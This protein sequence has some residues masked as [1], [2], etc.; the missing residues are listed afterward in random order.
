MIH[1]GIVAPLMTSPSRLT[2]FVS[3]TVRDFGPVR[4]DLKAWLEARAIYAR[5]SEHN[6]FPVA[7]GVHSHD[8]CLAAIAGCNLYVL[9]VGERYGGRYKGTPKSITWRE[10]DE[11][12]EHQI[13][14]VALVLKSA[15]DLTMELSKAR[16]SGNEARLTKLR[17]ELPRDFE[18][19]AKFID[20]L[21]KGHRDN[22]MYMDW[23]GSASG[24]TEVIQY[25]LNNL[26]CDYQGPYQELV[27]G[28]ELAAARAAALRD[29]QAA[30]FELSH[31]DARG[32]PSVGEALGRLLA[33]AASARRELF[34]FEPGEVWNLQLY[35]KEG[36][37]LIPWVRQCDKRIERQERRW[38]LDEGHVGL[39]VTAR[40][41]LVA[42][43]LPVA[44]GFVA[45][46]PADAHNYRSAVSVP[47]LGPP[48]GAAYVTR[49]KV[50]GVAHLSAT[51]DTIGA[52]VITSSRLDHFLE[53]N[54]PEVLTAEQL[55]LMLRMVATAA[56]SAAF[57]L[58]DRTAPKDVGA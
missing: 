47:L 8:S 30:T 42:G 49:K 58:D 5:L 35:R 18:N 38:K 56:P 39:A 34:K 57:A 52:F 12:Y 21:R 29:L 31:A 37:L 3:S 54:Q 50:A 43:D 55:C 10:Y 26:I 16:A 25:T 11:A 44:D 9:L 6:D 13:P 15:N 7:R 51:A 17:E 22:W 48:P 36:D 46:R 4:R 20:T 19:V 27:R 1:S 28:S 32:E 23:D 41:T 33:L 2:V 45:G 14:M 53:P 24:A 40:T